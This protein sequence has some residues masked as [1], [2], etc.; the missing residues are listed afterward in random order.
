MAGEQLLM[1]GSKY[2]QQEIQSLPFHFKIKIFIH[3]IMKDEVS[4]N[5]RC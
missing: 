4:K 5:R 3:E 2:K 1:S